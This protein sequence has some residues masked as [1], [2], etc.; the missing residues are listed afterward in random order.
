MTEIKDKVEYEHLPKGKVMDETDYAIRYYFTEMS[1]E[2][3]KEYDPNWDDEQLM[4][5]DDNFR[6]DGNLMLVCTERDID[7]TE[8]RK[9]LE[10]HLTFR[11]LS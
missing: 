6:S 10:E 1:D 11:E 8:Y 2:K 3:L 4:A 7:A 9:V 5:W